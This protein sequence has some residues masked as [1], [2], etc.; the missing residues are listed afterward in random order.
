[1]IGCYACLCLDACVV[2][3]DHVQ[4]VSD[5]LVIKKEFFIQKIFEDENQLKI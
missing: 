2:L 5:T 1:M 4:S 3:Y